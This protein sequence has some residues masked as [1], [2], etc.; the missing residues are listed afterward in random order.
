MTN[1]MLQD[2]DHVLSKNYSVDVPIAERLSIEIACI[3][4]LQPEYNALCN[5]IMPDDISKIIFFKVNVCSYSTFLRQSIRMYLNKLLS[6]RHRRY[7]R[8]F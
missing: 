7:S 8:V 1:K 5:A 3:T 4:L 2:N 6:S